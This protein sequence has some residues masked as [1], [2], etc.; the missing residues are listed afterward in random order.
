[1]CILRPSCIETARARAFL[2]VIAVAGIAEKECCRMEQDTT[3]PQK[4]SK[5]LKEL[6]RT[7]VVNQ[8]RRED[9]ATHAPWKPFSPANPAGRRAR[10]TAAHTDDAL[11][12]AAT[13]EGAGA[14]A[15]GPNPPTDADGECLTVKRRSGAEQIGAEPGEA[16][17]TLS[18]AGQ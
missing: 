7:G 15:G 1:M 13:N 8:D 17:T 3:K 16:S 11:S 2:P 18:H 4:L 9:E 14:S 5:E 10:G 12:S 6:Q